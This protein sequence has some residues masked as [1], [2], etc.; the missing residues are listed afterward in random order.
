[1]K[2]ILYGER[3]CYVFDSATDLLPVCFTSENLG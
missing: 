2:V 1:M 3:E